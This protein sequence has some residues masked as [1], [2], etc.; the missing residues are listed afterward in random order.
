MFPEKK[1]PARAREDFR[2]EAHAALEK[3][4]RAVIMSG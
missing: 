1:S 3:E 2:K 4:T